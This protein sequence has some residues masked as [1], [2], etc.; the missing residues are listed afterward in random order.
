MVM[1]S[2]I[3]PMFKFFK[4]LFKK[5]EADI[6]IKVTDN[7]NPEKAHCFDIVLGFD[8]APGE[9]TIDIHV[10]RVALFAANEMARKYIDKMDTSML[11]STVATLCIGA[12]QH[13]TTSNK[14]FV[15]GNPPLQQ[16]PDIDLDELLPPV[17][18]SKLN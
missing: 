18:K 14:D 6:T 16:L 2:K 11:K 4:K 7:I 9:G 17:D 1:S 10:N 5:K 15:K 12:S 13:V 8:V 3:G